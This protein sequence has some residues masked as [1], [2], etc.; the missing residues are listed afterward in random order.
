MSAVEKWRRSLEALAVPKE[1]L[2]AA[3]DTP[4]NLPI[5]PFRRRAEAALAAEPSLST[6]KA[7]EALPDGG[8]V[9]DVGVGAGAA[10]LPLRHRASLLVGV[11]ASEEML[12]EFRRIAETQ[13]ATVETYAGAWQDIHPT[14][15]VGDVAVC[16]HV[17]YN[18]PNLELLIKPLTAHARRRVVLEMT[19]HHPWA[20]AADLWMHFHGLVYPQ[21]PTSDDAEAAINEMG[22]MPGRVDLEIERRSGAHTRQDVV[23]N[24]RRRL[25]LSAERD[26]EIIEALGNR[27]VGHEGGWSAGP[28]SQKLT[29]FWWD[30][31][32][33]QPDA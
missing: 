12:S 13:Q 27:L 29:T 19:Q 33:S 18:V 10:S 22:L 5:E 15:P 7:L 21:E 23:A 9:I 11:D 14:V 31:T 6:A 26:D 17:I 8:V 24:I 25:C 3:P 32:R 16:H 20:W 30:T 2:D 28:P 4:W 1:I